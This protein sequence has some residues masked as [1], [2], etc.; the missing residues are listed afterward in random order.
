LDYFRAETGE[1][2]KQKESFEK[3]LDLAQRLD[4][5][6]IVHS[7][8]ASQDTISTLKNFPQLKK[9]VFHCFSGGKKTAKKILDLGFFISFTGIFTFPNAENMRVVA[10]EIPLNRMMLE[11]DCPFL[12][13]QKFRGKR[14]EPAYV[15][16]IAKEMARIKGV[17]LEELAVETT[18]NAESFFGI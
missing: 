8:D 9:V 1:I 12:A 18:R 2:S 5:P 11:T 4:M 6:A 7:R 14:N 3:Q 17:S 13:P 15:L 10:R 16:E